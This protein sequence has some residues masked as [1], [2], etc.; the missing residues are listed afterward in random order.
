MFE[1]GTSSEQKS[2]YCWFVDRLLKWWYENG[3][4]NYP[5]RSTTNPYYV[6]I[7]EMLLQRT[8]RDSVA[9]IYDKF[10]EKYPDPK[11]LA[12]AD[13]NELEELLKPLGLRK[14]AKIILEFAK[15]V[16]SGGIVA[17]YKELKK[18]PG[19]GD[20]IASIVLSVVFHENVAAVDKNI[21]RIFIRLFGLTPR[22]P[23]RPQ[24]DPLIRS[25]ANKCLPLGKSRDYNLALL[26]LGWEVCKPR[27]P[28]C[29]VCPLQNGCRYFSSSKKKL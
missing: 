2:K 28:R 26:D 24:D 7:A 12:N 9:K 6:I 23:A 16:S 15:E 3:P 8:R 14:R 10:I 29:D 1:M 21:A 11:R 19:V 5:W 18:L 27:N 13:I 20:Y 25:I 4:W 17:N 22:N